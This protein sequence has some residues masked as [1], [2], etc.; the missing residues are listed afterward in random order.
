MLPRGHGTVDIRKP[1]QHTDSIRPQERLLFTLLRQTEAVPQRTDIMLP[2]GHGT[3]DIRKPPQ[4]TDS[5][6]PQERLLFTL[7]PPNTHVMR[8]NHRPKLVACGWAY[9]TYAASRGR[10]TE[11]WRGGM[12]TTSSTSFSWKTT[13]SGSNRFDGRADRTL[14]M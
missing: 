11:F 5:I 3:V 7:S 2:R 13:A 12:P 4:H 14:L 6:Q 9:I 10:R 8:N 1:P